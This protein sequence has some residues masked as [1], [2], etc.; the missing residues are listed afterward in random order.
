MSIKTFKRKEIKYRINFE[1]F[2]ALCKVLEEYMVP[3]K[4][5]RD[6]KSYT[7][8]NLYFDTEDDEIIKH[9]ISKPYFKEKLRLRTY[10][11]PTEGSDK[12]FFELKKKIGGT[13]AKR[14]A[15]IPYDAA[16]KFINTGIYS[17]TDN[18]LDRQVLEEIKEFLRINDAKPK[19]FISYERIAFFDKQNKDFRVSFDRNILTRRDNL[20]F[21]GGNFGSKLIDDDEYIMEIKLGSS[22][23]LWLCRCLSEMKV[24]STSFSKYGNEYKRYIKK[25]DFQ[26]VI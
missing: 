14:R 18:Y 23:P 20:N 12:V 22:I 11:M 16:M 5:C 13:V 9:S 1:Q 24:F 4:Y 3:D 15:T 10:E 25:I 19:V 6:N 8:Y 21:T 2:E 7:I 26:G 17:E